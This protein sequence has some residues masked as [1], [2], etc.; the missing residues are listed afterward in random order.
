M[1]RHKVF[2]N[3]VFKESGNHL[4]RKRALR[5]LSP[6]VPPALPPLAHVPKSH[7]QMAFESLQGWRI[8]QGSPCS[9]EICQ[10]TLHKPSLP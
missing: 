9:E 3:Q 10:H 4:G 2:L 5:S 6:T 1:E 8:L 7:I